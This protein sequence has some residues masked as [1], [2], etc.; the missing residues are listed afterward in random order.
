MKIFK[1]RTGFT[2]IELSIAIVLFGIVCVMLFSMFSQ[3]R[4]GTIQTRDEITALEYATTILNYSRS[5]PFTDP[6]LNP[7][8]IRR[9][10]ELQTPGFSPVEKLLVVAPAF[11][12]QLSIV[13]CQVAAASSF[14]YKVL[15]VDVKWVSGG[16]SR[17]ISLT[18]LHFGVT[19]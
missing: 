3:A 2:L 8:E 14:A 5:L 6:F 19:E 4:T 13:P 18:A 11:E 10:T 17:Q 1:Q 12:C 7:S 15:R 9:I 16:V